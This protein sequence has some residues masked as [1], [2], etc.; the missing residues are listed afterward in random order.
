MFLSE[1]G[2]A[3]GI[4]LH[5]LAAVKASNDDHR[6]WAQRRLSDVFGDVRDM[7]IALW[8]LTYKPGTDTLRRSS[9]VELAQWLHQRGARVVAHDPAVKTLPADVARFVELRNDP[10]EAVDGAHA[11]VVA[12]PWPEFRGIE[13]SQAA[14]RMAGTLVLDANRFLA[15]TLGA[16]VG[17]R[18]VSVGRAAA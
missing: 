6:Q 12:T 7:T 1:L 11:L 16:Q 13:A 18:Y 2:V 15:A 5:L 4:P 14:R 3:R 10:L 9:A 17:L 8:G